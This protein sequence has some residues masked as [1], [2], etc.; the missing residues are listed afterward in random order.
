MLQLMNQ[1]RR[2]DN[3]SMTIERK[4]DSK[5][6]AVRISTEILSISKNG[7]IDSRNKAGTNIVGP[8]LTFFE[9]YLHKMDFD[10]W[11]RQSYY[12]K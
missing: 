5:V 3:V 9:R 2:K 1:E 6:K 7:V 12:Q 8:R 11:K 4:E 10:I